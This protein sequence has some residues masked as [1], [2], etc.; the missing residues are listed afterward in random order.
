MY[1]MEGALPGC[2]MRCP[3]VTRQT[4]RRAPPAGTEYPR[5]VPVSPAPPASR[6]YPRTVPVSNGESIS[7]AFPVVAQESAGIHFE[8]FS[9]HM[10]STE[11]RQLSAH[12]VGYPPAYAQLIHKL[13]SV[14]KRVLIQ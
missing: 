9:L 13:P 6:G 7:T 5:E 4:P 2:A 10:I 3:P 8:F 12:C 14:S 11:H 1:E